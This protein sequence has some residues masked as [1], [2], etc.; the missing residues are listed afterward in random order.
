MR[1]RKGGREGR[2]EEVGGSGGGGC[3]SRDWGGRADNVEGRMG[4]LAPDQV[5]GDGDLILCRFYGASRY[6]VHKIFGFLTP[7]PLVRIWI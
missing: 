2:G 6:D 1:F 3:Q 7:S 5:G 4:H